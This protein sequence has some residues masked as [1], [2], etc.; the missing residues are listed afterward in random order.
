MSKQAQGSNKKVKAANDQAFEPFRDQAISMILDDEFT[1][2]EIRKACCATTRHMQEL[3]AELG[4]DMSERTRRV[5]MRR[6]R[7]EQLARV[8]VGRLKDDLADLSLP[9]R[10]IYTQH[11]I[12]P[13][14]LRALCGQLGIDYDQRRE[15]YNARN[16]GRPKDPDRFARAEMIRESLSGDG[17]SLKLLR[18][19]WRVSA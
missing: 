11:G 14:T 2:D 3:Q 19:P 9:F 17:M 7:C 12:S 8:D 5:M 4:V 16:K 15:D 1:L 18:E 10:D 13:Q 6:N